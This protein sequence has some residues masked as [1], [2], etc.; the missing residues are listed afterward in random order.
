MLKKLTVAMIVAVATI[1]PLSGSAVA[2]DEGVGN[3]CRGVPD[4]MLLLNGHVVTFICSGN[5]ESPPPI[6]IVLN[7]P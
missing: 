2:V 5:I 1:L 7:K 3:Q 6:V 4:Y